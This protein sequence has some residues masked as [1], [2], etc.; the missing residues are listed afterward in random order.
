ME[1]LRKLKKQFNQ[2]LESDGLQEKIEH[3]LSSVGGKEVQVYVSKDSKSRAKVVVLVDGHS[4]EVSEL[5]RF[6]SE[7]RKNINSQ[8]KALTNYIPQLQAQEKEEIKQLLVTVAP[9]K[10]VDLLSGKE[11]VALL[12]SVTIEILNKIASLLPPL[13]SFVDSGETVFHIGEKSLFSLKVIFTWREMKWKVAGFW[14]GNGTRKVV[15]NLGRIIQWAE[16]IRESDGN[17]T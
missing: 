6:V 1:A 7:A 14:G 10:V 5:T 9:E 8:A 3:P 2:Y 17:R 16:E 4:V 15:Y 13:P 12:Q 11:P